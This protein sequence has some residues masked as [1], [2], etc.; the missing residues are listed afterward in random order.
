MNK[1]NISRNSI[2][3]PLPITPIPNNN[4]KSSLNYPNKMQRLNRLDYPNNN[5]N[6]TGSYP[7]NNVHSLGKYITQNHYIFRILKF[8]FFFIDPTPSIVPNMNY[9]PNFYQTV[10]NQMSYNGNQQMSSS[11]HAHYNNNPTVTDYPDFDYPNNNFQY[12]NNYNNNNYQRQ[13]NIKEKGYNNNY[14]N[15]QNY[16]QQRNFNNNND[17][18]PNNN[19]RHQYQLNNSQQRSTNL[20]SNINNSNNHNK[21]AQNPDQEDGEIVDQNKFCIFINNLNTTKKLKENINVQ[22]LNVI[23]FGLFFLFKKRPSIVLLYFLNY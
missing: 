14:N 2:T 9:V 20:S 17:Y 21:R 7:F 11:H 8:L 18:R 16:N 15:F 12:Y 1:S 10:M 19:N 5:N 23:K 13:G 6:M 22:N 4:N 3:P